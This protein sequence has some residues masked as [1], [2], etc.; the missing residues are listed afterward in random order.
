MNVVYLVSSARLGGTETSVVEM[1]SSLREAHPDWSFRAVVPQ[2]GPLVARLE[3]CGARATVLPFPPALAR[4]GEA[5]H[6]EL[7]WRRARLAA[8][9]LTAGPAALRYT[10]RLARAIAG[11][12]GSAGVVHAH[13]FKMLV[14]AARAAPRHAVLVW[15][16]HDYVSPRP[17]SAWLVRHFAR[18]CDVAI[19][20]S[21]SVAEDV[22]RVCGPG[23]RVEMVHNAIDL[24]RFS[25][26]GPGADLDALAGAPPAPARTI[27]IGLLG[28]FGR[29]K[30]HRVFLRALAMLPSALAVRGY[31]IGAAEY[32]TSGSQ[33]SDAAL[34]RAVEELGLA[35]SVFFTGS[36]A[37]PETALRSLDI[38]AHAS[39][40]PEPFGMVIAEAMACGR[41]V[42]A[43][44]AGGAAE[45]FVD[46]V[47]ALGHTPG[48]AVDLASRLAL[49][50]GDAA[51]RDRLG[52]AARKTAERRFDR[53]RLARQIAPLY[54]SRPA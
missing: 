40:E 19:A 2:E 11:P 3:Q 49:L 53:A 31:I 20:N 52:R 26:D 5:G 10:R 36:V 30:G 15:H 9:A 34:R 41:A 50:A 16:F 18:R 42:V 28:T 38:V 12:G 29:W 23:L 43:A 21:G 39:T 46:G 35:Q 37:H 51:L 48:D 4:L 25:P 44:R 27:R 33:E 47:D 22:R 7:A 32:Q 45:L 8:G 6:R 24:S 17:L 1:I 13:G 14:L 54:G